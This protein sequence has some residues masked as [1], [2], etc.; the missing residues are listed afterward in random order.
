MADV[1]NAAANVELQTT[2][3]TAGEYFQGVAG[4]VPGL[5]SAVS[6]GEQFEEFAITKFRADLGGENAPGVGQVAAEGAEV[7]LAT[8]DFVAEAG[9]EITSIIEDPLGWVVSAGM[10]ML[11]S[12]VT[13]LQDMLHYVT[14]DAPA[15][16]KG[17]ENFNAIAEGLVAMSDNLVQVGDDRLKEWQGEASK[18]GKKALA[19][20]AVGIDGVSAASVRVAEV[21]KNSA[22]LMQ[23]VEA[24]I[25]S[26]ITDFVSYAIQVLAP[27]L[28]SA[29]FPWGAR[30][31]L[32]GGSSRRGSRKRFRGS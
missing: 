12:V 20:F 11:L 32:R 23:S 30:L 8:A 6:V 22:I 21:V 18:A 28:A 14:G 1:E 3:R 9:S 15:L 4:S 25:K 10:D 24:V 27:A 26:L 7:V 2:D 5:S 31:P 19:Q 13:P 16:E 17:A 29:I